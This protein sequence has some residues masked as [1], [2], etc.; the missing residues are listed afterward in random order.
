MEAAHEHPGIGLGL[1]FLL[2][3][4]LRA[5]FGEHEQRESA[6]GYGTQDA[7]PGGNHLDSPENVDQAGTLSRGFWSGYMIHKGRQ[8]AG[9]L[10]GIFSCCD[11]PKLKRF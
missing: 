11:G 5:Y 4:D 6:R 1:R 8:K 3:K 7:G 9:M 2:S 10:Q